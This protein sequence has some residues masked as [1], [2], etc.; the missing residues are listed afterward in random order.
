MFQKEFIEMSKRSRV[1]PQIKEEGMSFT[2]K[3]KPSLPARVPGRLWTTRLQQSPL[4]VG[5]G[6]SKEGNFLWKCL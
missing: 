3:A 4:K 6:R 1:E 2:K 5:I